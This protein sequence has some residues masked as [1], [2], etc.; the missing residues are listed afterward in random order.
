MARNLHLDARP[1]TSSL[2]RVTFRMRSLNW[3]VALP[4]SRWGW[5]I[6]QAAQA[7]GVGPCT[8]RM[9]GHIHPAIPP[10]GHWPVVGVPTVP[11]FV[12]LKPNPS[13]PHH[14]T[15]HTPNLSLEVATRPSGCPPDAARPRE[16]CWVASLTVAPQPTTAPIARA[17]PSSTTAVNDDATEMQRATG[18]CRH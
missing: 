10:P 3:S 6:G 12:P 2:G 4:G 11:S 17:H 16:G 7:L 13:T 18:S 8:P 5:Q 14:H 9:V 15:P 1:S